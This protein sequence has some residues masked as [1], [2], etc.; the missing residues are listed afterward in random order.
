[1]AGADGSF[2]PVAAPGGSDVFIEAMH[3]EC[4]YLF[5]CLECA[6]LSMVQ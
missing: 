5:K 6:M 2:D 4:Y 3:I 1:M